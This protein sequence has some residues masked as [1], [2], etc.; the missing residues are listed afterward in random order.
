MK[1]NYSEHAAYWDWDMYDRSGELEFWNKMGMKY[2]KNVLS[3]MC[4]I[5]QAALYMA[6]KGYCVTALDYTEEMILEGRKRYGNVRGLNFVQGDIRNYNFNKCFDFCFIDGTDLHLLLSLED[7][8]MALRNI[9]K[10]L[11]SGGGFGLEIEYPFEQSHSSP[12]RRFDPRVPRNDGT[13]IWKE[14]NSN[15]NVVTKRQD[16][17]QIIYVQKDGK[18]NC[19]DHFVS[20]QYYDKDVIFNSFQECGFKIADLYCDRSF[21]KSNI[22]RENCFIELEKE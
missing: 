11:R 19:I 10:H 6:N 3:P 22:P 5:G 7:V 1:T 4:A 17:H 12:M 16:I 21:N 20:L 8:K 2:G 13:T 14:G 15:Y 9:N 18:T